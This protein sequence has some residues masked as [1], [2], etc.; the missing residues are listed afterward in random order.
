FVITTAAF[1]RFLEHN[2]L[3]DQIAARLALIAED[4]ADIE[5]ASETVRGM[6]LG[7]EIPA[8]LADSL[9]SAVADLQQRLGRKPR[10][11]VRS[12]A[13][14][15]DGKA[16]FAGQY[17]T[18]LNV[19]PSELETSYLRVLASAYS[20][21]AIAYR[22]QRGLRD[23]DARMAVGCIELVDAVA[24]GVMF[25]RDPE[26]GDKPTVLIDAVPGQGTMAVDGGVIPDHF[27][28]DRGPPLAICQRT[29][30]DK[31]RMKVAAPWGGL[32]EMELPPERRQTPCIGDVHLLELAEIALRL[33]AHFGSPQDIEWALDAKGAI[34]VLQSR[35]LSLEHRAAVDCSVREESLWGHEILAEGGAVA[36]AGVGAG[37]VFRLEGRT[38]LDRVP[39][40]AVLVARHSSPA[41]VRV[42][43]RV[44]AIVTEAGG[45]TGHMAIVARE[46]GIPTIVGAAAAAALPTG[47]EVTVDAYRARVYRGIAKALLEEQKAKRPAPMKG[48]PIFGA[49]E[50]IAVHIC[51]LHL[52]DP[53][54]PSF[55]PES[56]HSLHDLIRYAHES[57]FAEMFHIGN[58]VK[59]ADEA[60][61]RRLNAKLPIEVYV[62]DLGGALR[63]R[64]ACASTGARVGIEA[65]AE[66]CAVADAHASANAS[67]DTTA[68]ANANADADTDA[69]TEVEVEQI[70]SVPLKAFVA[71]LRDPTIRWDRPRP[72]SVGGFLSVLGES[73]MNPPPSK[74]G[75]GRRSFA[76]ASD[77]YL[78]FSTRAGYHFSTLDTYCGHSINKNYIHFRFV[79]GAAS[80][81]R[82]SR[83][84]RFVGLV[85]E[86]LGF[87][88]QTK[89]DL[90]TAR[91][92]K[93]EREIIENTLR[94][95]GRLT[96][97]AR[98]LDMLMDDDSRVESFAD[99]FLAGKY[100]CFA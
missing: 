37:A 44:S 88:I 78:N 41:F 65:E 4:T 25:G 49:L 47:L 20:P 93:F 9:K 61:A 73:M 71:G 7:A 29:I 46:F 17:Q 70:L 31:S 86:K 91:M 55:T 63:S 11:A 12:S 16:S 1:D 27:V 82:R 51:P 5:A 68:N 18:L 33:E 74:H 42:M 35:P 95:L 3:E 21:V 38:D 43:R 40:G 6:I 8:D 96:L 57:L 58:D 54:A 90:V 53:T 48:T 79:G 89:G 77:T 52:I 69:D 80:T 28:I 23:E 24:A 100:D 10:L 64:A 39:E 45:V 59:R 32:V 81:E 99:S 75:L 72:V 15:E 76:M 19:E 83:R 87:A 50:R 60:N 36:C 13:V 97:C 98:Q 85:L 26:R 22:R 56:C 2:R 84:A 92:Q 62:F 14:G 34:F 67:A 94:I 30:S 66:T